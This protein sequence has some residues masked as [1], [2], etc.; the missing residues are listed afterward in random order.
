M[1]KGSGRGFKGVACIRCGSRDGVT[2]R[3]DDT[4]KFSCGECSEDFTADDVLNAIEKWQAVL[5]WVEMA[6]TL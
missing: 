1:A 6:P 2:V 3:L 5:A 4:S